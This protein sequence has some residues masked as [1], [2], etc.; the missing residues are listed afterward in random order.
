MGVR[1]APG[2]GRATWCDGG[3]RDRG[4]RSV[5]SLLVI[6][7]AAAVPACAE[8][9]GASDAGAAGADVASPVEPSHPTSLGHEDAA[10]PVD[11][12]VSLPAYGYYAVRND[13]PVALPAVTLTDHHGDDIRIRPPLMG[14]VVLV[15]FGY[16]NCPDL[17]PSE[18][19]TVAT[20][21]RGL[22]PDIA[23][24]VRMHF[25]TID[26]AR[27]SVARMREYVGLFDPT[28]I[29]LRGTDAVVRRFQLRLGLLPAERVD[30][31]DD[32]SYAMRHSAEVF[33]FTDDGL[34]HLSFPF[35]MSVVQWQHDLWKMVQIGWRQ[36]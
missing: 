4:R 36:P 23:A 3:V 13:P 9:G 27:D 15:Y 20:A 35:G 28:F 14:E 21:L 32:D 18:L 33:A 34:G 12:A 10:L 11:P 26:P 22:P 17:C 24:R 16:T 29:G 6:V 5:C 2:R 19:G 8:T 1:S 30:T 31:G 25:V 7:L